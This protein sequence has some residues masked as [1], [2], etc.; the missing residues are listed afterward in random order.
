[1]NKYTN[2]NGFTL[3]ELIIFMGLFSIIITILTSLFAAT[4]QQQMST[5]ALSSSES[6][7]AYLLARLEYDIDRATSVNEPFAI[8]E[9]SSNLELTISGNTYQYS[10]IDGVLLLETPT[11]T[12]RLTNPRSTVESISFQKIGNTGGAPTI[13]ILMQIKGIAENIPVP[14]IATLDTTILLR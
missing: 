13:K 12:H 10:V 14:Q 11:G 2:Q 9:T 1:M 4:V 5:Q 7:A 3:I 6:D 8:G